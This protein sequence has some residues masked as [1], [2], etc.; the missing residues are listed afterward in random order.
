VQQQ[1]DAAAGRANGAEE[2]R[3][4]L[5]EVAALMVYEATRSFDTKRVKVTTPLAETQGLHHWRARVILV[6]V[7]AGGLGNAA[8]HLAI[9][10]AARVGCH[11]PETARGEPQA[12]VYTQESSGQ[13]APPLKSF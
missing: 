12:S 7:V 5:A 4:G 3:R 13:R 1:P 9:D 6:P 10:P 2:F 11:R 8:V